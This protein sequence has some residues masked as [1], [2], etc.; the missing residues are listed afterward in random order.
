MKTATPL[1][2]DRVYSIDTLRLVSIFFVILH[3]ASAFKYS[4]YFYYPNEVLKFLYYF[5]ANV[6][7]LP[8]FFIAAG[9]FFRKGI[10]QGE[11]MRHRFGRYCKRLARL[12]VLWYFIYAFLMLPE[13]LS[14]SDGYNPFEVFYLNILDVIKHPFVSAL[15]GS[16]E[17]L[18]FFPA[19]IM[20]LTIVVVFHV[21]DKEK[22]IVPLGITLYS[23]VLLSKSYSVLPWGYQVDFEMRQGPFVSTLFVGIGWML[24]KKNN[25]HLK[26]ALLLILAGIFMQMLEA[27]F[28]YT[29]YDVKPKHGY[30]FGTILFCVGIFIFILARPNIGKNTISPQWGK[31]TLGVYCVHMIFIEYFKLFKPHLHPIAYDIL[32]PIAVYLLSIF[33]TFLLARNSLTRK[34]VT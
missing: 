22:Y 33:A 4:Y 2:S 29:Q 3:H 15:S 20:G 27:L 18:W 12:F 14:R 8:F 5:F 32:R 17:H 13:G 16:S 34:L 10:L 25:F 6:R 31:L 28:L 24:A 1:G 9:Y 26:T 23:I 30:L 21:L 19:V 7:L 11:S